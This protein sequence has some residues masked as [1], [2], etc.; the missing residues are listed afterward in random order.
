MALI[1]NSIGRKDGGY[2]RLFGDSALGHL[3]SRVQGAVISSGTELARIIKDRVK[4]I[5]DLDEFLESEIMPEGVYVADKLKVKRCKSLNFAGA[6]PDFIIFKRR[7]NIQR[8]HVVELK[9]GDS[10]D[11]KK[12]A[13]EHTF[14][15]EQERATPSIYSF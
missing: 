6:E 2:G 5:D 1:K 11:T 8:C 15:C 7:N 3:I 4:L 10:F 12:S 9:D 14:L 13:S